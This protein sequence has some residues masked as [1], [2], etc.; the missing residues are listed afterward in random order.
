MSNTV[1]ILNKSENKYKTNNLLRDT[2]TYKK[3]RSS[4]KF[5]S[6]KFNKKGKELLHNVPNTEASNFIQ[7][8]PELPYNY[9]LPNIRKETTRFRPII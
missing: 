7:I 6:S 1:V 3:L 5:L 9:G 4:P 2:N 8:S